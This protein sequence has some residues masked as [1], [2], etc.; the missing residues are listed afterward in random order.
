MCI[1][2]NNKKWLFVL[3]LFIGIFIM[4]AYS[5][6][7]ILKEKQNKELE[8]EEKR[9]NDLKFEIQA[10]AYE[11]FHYAAQKK[12]NNPNIGCVPF[13]PFENS[14]VGSVDVSS[15]EYY[16]WISDGTFYATGTSNNLTVIES[17]EEASINCNLN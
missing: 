14:Y 17:D 1:K 5:R 7:I 9:K 8:T 13:F 12:A 16:I 6:I 11:M 4:T 3:I 10:Y 2:N 15:G